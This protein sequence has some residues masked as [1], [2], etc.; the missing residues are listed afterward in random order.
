MGFAFVWEINWLAI[1]SILGV[2]V[3]FITRT[4]NED[5]EYTLPAA[6]VEKLEEARI[7]KTSGTSHGKNDEMD[8][9]MGL[10]QFIKIVLGFFIDVIRNK[11]W[12]TW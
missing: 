3:F 10:G 8:E 1:A 6:K 9:D 11:R 12:R 5:V 4:F 7:K 2:I